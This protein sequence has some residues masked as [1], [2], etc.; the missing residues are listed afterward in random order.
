MVVAMS[1]V[2]M[3][4][5]RT[6]GA[7]AIA[8]CSRCGEHALFRPRLNGDGGRVV[9]AAEGFDAHGNQGMNALATNVDPSGRPWTGD[10]I[11]GFMTC[12]G[13]NK[14]PHLRR[15][16]QVRFFMEWRSTQAQS[17]PTIG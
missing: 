10:A 2:R 7:A 8:N 4:N 11:A 3:L 13:R 16:G 6:H 9:C 15:V 17:S 1:N 14:E 5:R 12:G